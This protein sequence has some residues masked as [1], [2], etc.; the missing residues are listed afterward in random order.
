M[1][2]T[3]HDLTGAG[4]FMFLDP[5]STGEKSL[6]LSLPC[7]GARILCSCA[8]VAPPVTCKSETHQPWVADTMLSI[9]S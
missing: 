3:D 8:S 1:K 5:L 2:A 7:F 4:I 6:Q 9:F